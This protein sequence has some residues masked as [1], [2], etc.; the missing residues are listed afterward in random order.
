MSNLVRCATCKRH[1]YAS[2]SACPFCARK[3]AGSFAVALTAA[4][5]I[6]L[7]GCGNDPPKNDSTTEA[8]PEA[9]KTEPT[10]A[11]PNPTPAPTPTPTPAPVPTPVVSAAE[12]APSASAAASATNSTKPPP[13][14]NVDPPVRVA[15]AYGVPPPKDETTPKKPPASAYGAPPKPSLDDR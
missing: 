9:R 8:A 10:Q 13:K 2:E 15:P 11:A 14:V 12:P 5:S 1:I 4:A 3:G 7:A 6:T